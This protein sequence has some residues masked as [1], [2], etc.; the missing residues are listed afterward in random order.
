MWMAPRMTTEQHIK[1]ISP[2]FL[3]AH[4]KVVLPVDISRL[5]SM[6]TKQFNRL[7]WTV[8]AKESL[9]DNNGKKVKVLFGRTHAH[10]S[11]S[12]RFFGEE[13]R[14]VPFL[15]RLH[16]RGG[17][18]RLTIDTVEVGVISLIHNFLGV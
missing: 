15:I 13:L 16:E 4:K 1:S 18:T 11:F 8:V 14:S 3:M 12:A 5:S 9:Y 10:D 7:S 2:F 17:K 6:L